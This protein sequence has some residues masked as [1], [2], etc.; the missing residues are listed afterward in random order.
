MSAIDEGLDGWDHVAVLALG[1]D[2][3]AISEGREG[4]V[5]PARAAVHGDMLVQVGGHEALLTVVQ[6]G[7]EVLGFNVGV[8][9]GGLNLFTSGEA[10]VQLQRT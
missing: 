2:L 5:S 9:L 6:G 4:R 7:W 8:G 3:E 10:V 1:L